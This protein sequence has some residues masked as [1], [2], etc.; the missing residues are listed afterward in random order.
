MDVKIEKLVYGG[1]GLGHHEGHTVFVPFVLP[2]EVVTVQ[3]VERKKKFV[4]GRVSHVLTPSPQRATPPCPHFAV[5]GGCHYQHIPYEAQLPYKT[6][7]LRETFRRL[8]R[9]E[10]GGPI[11]THASPPFGYRNRAQWK[12]RPAGAAAKNAIGY[13]QAGSSTLCAVDECPVLSPRLAETLAGLRDLLAESRLPAKLRE[14][15]A[16]T[17]DADRKVLL[18]ASV[19]TF[20]GPPESLA[21]LLL[22][23]LPGVETILLQEIS[24]DRYELFGPGFIHYH[25]AGN[26][27]RV[28]HL[29]FFQVNRFL[30]EELVHTVL[31]E[32][33][34][35][36]ALDLFA[37]VGLFT[38]PLAKR[39]ERVVGVESDLAAARDLQANIE[40]SKG[41]AQQVNAAV[42]SL[43][44]EWQ[45]RPDYVVLDPPRAGVSD[46]ALRQLLRLGPPRLA[47]LSCDPATLARDLRVLTG[48]L[49]PAAGPGAYQIA[50]V[51]LF[52]LFPQTYHIESLVRLKRRE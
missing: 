51:H 1:E 4:R 52:D 22:T 34:G 41:N 17:D 31:A 15:E 35:K 21:S 8:G 49:D 25:A 48:G 23:A 12:I 36:L 47:Y 42:E 30:I 40:E 7:I 38:L 9:V 11:Q 26:R 2:D 27:C 32:E 18:N 37:G 14:V 24:R 44:T 28:G 46:G 33:R 45:E 3:P 20:D 29:S 50:E 5:C 39:F 19:E 43:L 6:E 13:F 16:F 10:W